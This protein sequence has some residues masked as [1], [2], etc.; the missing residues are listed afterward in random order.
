MVVKSECFWLYGKSRILAVGFFYCIQEKGMRSRVKA[1]CA[2]GSWCFD[3]DGVDAEARGW[4][5]S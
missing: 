4:C 3:F 2:V 5:G 1:E